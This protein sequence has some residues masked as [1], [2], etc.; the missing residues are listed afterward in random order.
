[1][2]VVPSSNHL[3]AGDVLMVS[4]MGQLAR[5]PQDILNTL[6]TITGRKASVQSP[7][8][9]DRGAAMMGWIRFLSKGSV[10]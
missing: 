8:N 3:A 9:S 1:M 7:R 2:Q 10:V 6:S 5:S 4:K